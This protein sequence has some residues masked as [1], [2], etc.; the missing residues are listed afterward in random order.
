[1]AQSVDPED[2]DTGGPS[3]MNGD[4]VGL[5]SAKNARRGAYMKD[6]PTVY[7]L[8]KPVLKSIRDARSRE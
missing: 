1:M 6:G 4:S 5:S 2:E 7:K 8:V 3:S